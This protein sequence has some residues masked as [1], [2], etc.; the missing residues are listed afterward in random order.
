[1]GE[2]KP[3]TENGFSKNI[4]NGV[5]DN[6]SIDRQVTRSISN[7]PDNWIQSPQDKSETTD[8]SKEL[9][10]RSI[11]SPNGLT[12]WDD[13]LVDNHEICSTCHSI[14]S[15]LLTLCRTECGKETKE[16]H[17]QVC[18]NGDENVGARHSSEE[19]EIEQEKRGSQTP[20]NVTS[21][22][23]LA[24]DIFDGVWGVL[25]CFLDDDLGVGVSVTRGHGEVG[26]GR[27]E[28]DEGCDDMEESFLLEKVR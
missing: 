20:I 8:A 5:A 2:K 6:L 1:M 7:T 12:T 19:C 22:E 9:G 16:N 28:G 4:K 26:D 11:L 17:D 14:V 24:V 3:E 13:K 21:P 27:E 25:V 18:N 23:Y 15:P 10:S